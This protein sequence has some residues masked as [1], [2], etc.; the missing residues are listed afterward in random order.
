MIPLI[1][2]PYAYL[3]LLA[4]IGVTSSF[5]DQWMNLKSYDY[6]VETLIIVYLVSTLFTIFYNLIITLKGKYTAYEAAKINLLVKGIQVPAYI[7]HFVIGMM[8]MVMSVWGIGLILFAV[9][10]DLITILLTGINSIGCSIRMRKENIL[11]TRAAV[12]MGIGCF[13]YCADL[14]IAVVYFIHA[15]K[16]ANPQPAQSPD[17]SPVLPD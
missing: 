4:F 2:F 14:V 7:F 10:V 3:I 12:L 16:K 5:F 11:T 9:V 1:L 6:T 17:F 8:G 15:R 13:I